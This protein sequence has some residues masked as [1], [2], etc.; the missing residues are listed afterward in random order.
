MTPT[1]YLFPSN[2]DPSRIIRLPF[3]TPQDA[4]SWLSKVES[5]GRRFYR[6]V[7]MADGVLAVLRKP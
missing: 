1:L 7:W 5:R 4:Q 2:G 6:A 3:T